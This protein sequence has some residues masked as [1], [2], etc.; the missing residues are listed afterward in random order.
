[1]CILRN[2]H[3]GQCRRIGDISLLMSSSIYRELSMHLPSC[4]SGAQKRKISWEAFVVSPSAVGGLFEE[5]TAAIGDISLVM[6]SFIYR[7]L[8]MHLP[9]NVLDSTSFG[10]PSA[11]FVSEVWN[12]K[13]L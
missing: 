4:S 6:S 7:D 1:M 13:I 8:S 11:F 12:L 5:Q 2:V 3:V 10:K 9:L